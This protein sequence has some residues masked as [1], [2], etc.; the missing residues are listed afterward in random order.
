MENSPQ[1]GEKCSEG[2]VQL[3]RN[4]A[5]QTD[6]GSMGGEAKIST[7]E[8]EKLTASPTRGKHNTLAMSRILQL[9][10]QKQRQNCVFF[11]MQDHVLL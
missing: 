9:I 10:S 6:A 3:W 11:A 7:G 2:T 1:R 5:I 4:H 8:R